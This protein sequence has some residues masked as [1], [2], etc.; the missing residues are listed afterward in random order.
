[1]NPYTACQNELVEITLTSD[2]SYPDPFNDVELDALIVSPDGIKAIIPAFWAGGTTWKIRYASPLVGKHPFRTRCSDPENTSLHDLR[3]TIEV[4]PY[5]GENPLLRHGALKVSP[6]RKYLEHAD[7]TPFLWLGD[8]WWYGLAERLKWPEEFGELV[9]DRVSKGFNVVQLVGGMLP[10]FTKFDNWMANEA[11]HPMDEDFK[12]VNPAYFDMADRRIS[13]LTAAGIVPCILPAWGYFLKL[14][15][16]EGMKKIWRYTVARWGAHCVIWCLAGEVRMPYPLYPLVEHPKEWAEA[17]RELQDGWTEIIKYLRDLDPYHHPVTAHPSPA[18]ASY[19][20]RD[21]FDDPSL[22]DIDRLQTGHL[23][24]MTQNVF[25]YT[26]EKL[27]KALSNRDVKPVVNGEPSY[28]GV[29]GGFCGEATQRF[30]FW[31]HLLKGAAGYTYGSAPVV[32]FTDR[33]SRYSKGDMLGSC[34]A[35]WQEGAYHF[36][37][38]AQLGLGKRFLEQFDWSRFEPHPEWVEPH[39]SPSDPFSPYCAGIPGEVRIIYLP[40]FVMP[41][42]RDSSY[43]KI[44]VLGIE[45]DV[46]YRSY[47][48]NPRNGD[49]LNR[50][51]VTPSRDGKWTLF[52][53]GHLFLAVPNLG[54]WIL[55]LEA[56]N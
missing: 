52:P 16:I 40:S 36:P 55:V 12:T 22:V 35:T 37:G 46:A 6:S 2:R 28:E 10:Y 23:G 14:A 51:E 50:T 8:T 34:D 21:L 3:G 53:E 4:S 19:S 31:T 18:D 30:L 43:E 1:M 47:F 32:F 39:A 56:K 48:F 29:G 9:Q 15:G 38:S 49:I 54:D 45:E 41:K 26:L 33:D 42:G 7:G 44:H 17:I 27:N 5:S 24:N 13:C 20:S 11:G 25:E